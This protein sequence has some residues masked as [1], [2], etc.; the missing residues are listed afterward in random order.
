MLTVLRGFQPLRK[1]AASNTAEIYHVVRLTGRGKGGQFAAKILREECADDAIEQTYLE[2]E[3]EICSQLEY[4][5]LVHAF[6]LY[7]DEPRPFLILDL[8]PGQNLRQCMEKGPVPMGQALGWLA[9]AAEGLAYFHEEGFV[10]RDVKPHNIMV[11]PEGV[12]VI[13]F[14]LAIEEDDSFS[15]HLLRRLKERRRPGTWSYMAPEQIQ[16]NRVTGLTDIYCLG[17]SL[18]EVVTGRLPYVA[19][20]QQALLEHHLY[21]KIPSL[22]AL[23]P[24]APP[25]LDDLV[26]TMMAKDPLD[27]P[28]SME[29]VCARLKSLAAHDS[30]AR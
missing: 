30:V 18:F 3:F 29:Y 21:G 16:N 15:R 4:P 24:D 17:V 23:R 22:R 27:R 11:G 2:N 26:R 7:M 14:A 10:H 19:D 25:G 8:I 28:A 20:T 1:L 12:K 9:Q 6:E 5:N 13:D